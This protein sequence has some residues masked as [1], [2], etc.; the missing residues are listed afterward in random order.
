MA[1]EL[2]AGVPARTKLT[3]GALTIGLS[4]LCASARPVAAEDN[5]TAE[6]LLPATT[7]IY[8]T[9]PHPSGVV[10]SLWNHPVRLRAMKIDGVEDALKTPQYLQFR[11]VVSIV[12]AQLGVTW[13]EA[14]KMAT[15]NG[16]HIGLDMETEGLVVLIQAEDASQRDRMLSK[17]IQ[18]ARDDAKR[19]GEEDPFESREYRGVTAYKGDNLVLASFGPWLMVTNKGEL[20]RQV[21][22]THQD[23]SESSLA[24]LKLF[25]AA[26]ESIESSPAAWGIVNLELIRD[27]GGAQ[28]LLR[29]RTDNILAEMLIGGIQ[30]RLLHAPFATIAVRGRGNQL[31]LEV[32]AHRGQPEKDDVREYY[33]GPEGDG[34]APALLRAD[35]TL[36]AV[37]MYRDLAQMWLR[38]GDL[39]TDQ[40][41]DQ[42][43]EADSNLSNLF[44]G[45]DFGE[46]ILGA[47]RPGIQLVVR[48]QVFEDR[49]PQPAVKLP[50][51]ALVMHLKDPAE[52]RPELRRIF[53][54]LIGFL[55]V[56]GA[57]NG[58]P[59]LD[60][61][62]K[63]D[64]NI[65]LVTTSYVPGRE[66]RESRE[67]RI[68]FNFSPSVGFVGDRFILSSTRELAVELTK[69][70]GEEPSSSQFNT[71]ARADVTNVVQVLQDNREQLIAQNML[72][73]GHE[74]AAAEREIDGLLTL[75]SFVEDARLQLKNSDQRLMLSVTVDVKAND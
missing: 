68:N 40:A 50:A 21:V 56:A 63:S 27:R 54:S 69:S 49:L 17:I 3:L 57:A 58:Q 16:L 39:V 64:A 46:D 59:Q 25:Q 43:N 10:E 26:R 51:L 74:R 30:S 29:D 52:M 14:L 72:E 67:A 36:L 32:S 5:T 62:M 31:Q 73:K 9:I 44:A 48:R 65:Q 55:N 70:S 47:M 38:S 19:K 41:V 4:L 22:D 2:T 15:A 28:E 33:F 20:A 13:R 75:L 23:G 8:F 7:A 53:Q 60:M 1:R 37:S 61:D 11:A 12:E 35:G 24:N 66:E 34:Q 45:K 71:D 6:Q 42:L 18:M